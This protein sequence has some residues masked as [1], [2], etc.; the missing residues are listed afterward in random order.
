MDEDE[1]LERLLSGCHPDILQACQRCQQLQGKGAYQS[2]VLLLY[3]LICQCPD[4]MES[5]PREFHLEPEQ[6]RIFATMLATQ[7]AQGYR[8]NWSL[9]S[10]LS[11]PGE[12]T[13][14]R[15]LPHLLQ[16]PRVIELYWWSG[17]FAPWV[18]QSGASNPFWRCPGGSQATAYGHTRVRPVHQF[19]EGLQEPR[20]QSR[21]A[22]LRKQAYKKV[23]RRS[24]H[25]L[26]WT[27]LKM[28]REAVAV[29]REMVMSCLHWNVEPT[30][31]H[32]SYS[33]LAHVREDFMSPEDREQV[34]E[35]LEREL[36]GQF[37]PG[38]L[39]IEG[40]PLGQGDRLQGLSLS[41]GA[42]TLLTMESR[43]E[44]AEKLL[45]YGR[46]GRW[47]ELRSGWLRVVFDQSVLQSIV[48]SSSPPF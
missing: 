14:A 39:S 16:Q 9:L 18:E 36:L 22:A 41:Q 27:C 13:P 26:P 6:V 4:L 46:V 19:L 23:H 7:P 30:P 3:A 35:E 21:F 20:C 34:R 43:F 8:L 48:W 11:G 32:L 33:A 10:L 28:S 38:E 31:L 24:P 2:E 25:A 44:E 29:L 15:L 40:Q 37:P 17:R 42:A 12:L 47:V 1:P 5:Y 45:G